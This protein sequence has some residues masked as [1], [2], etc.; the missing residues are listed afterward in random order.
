MSKLRFLFTLT[1]IPVLA[2]AFTGNVLAKKT[3]E[4]IHDAEYYVLEAQHGKKWAAEDKELDKKLAKMRKKHGTPP[5][6]IHIMWDDTAVGE[7]GV[8]Q[9]QKARGWETPNINKFS[10]EGIYFARMYTEPSCTPSRAAVMTGRHAVRNGMY[11][12]GFPYEYGGLAADEVTMGEVLSKAGYATAF[13]G[14]SHMGDVES[15]YL[16]KQGFDEALWTPYNQV[17]SMYPPEFERMGAI[18]PGSLNDNI[19]PNDPYDI[20]KGWKPTGYVFALEGV[21]GGPVSEWGTAP[22]IE[23]YIAVDG[24]CQKRLSKF[25]KKNVEAK[26]PF[27]AAYWPQMTPF[28]GFPEKITVSAGMLQEAIARFDVYVGEL[29]EELKTLGIEE[30]TLVI[31][32]ADNGPMIHHGPTGMVETL[33][34]GGKGDFLEGGVRVTAHARWPGV[35]EKGQIVGDIIHETD[36]FTTFANLADAKKYI[37]TDRIIDGIDQTALFLK[38]DTHSRRDYVFIYTGDQLAATVKGRYKRDWRNAVPGLSGA[39]FYDLYNDPREVYP[40]M[41]QL[42]PVKTMFSIMKTRHLMM[43]KA[44]P[45]KGQNRDFPFKNVVNARPETVKASKPRLDP[46]KLPFDP[47]EAIMQVPE[48]DNLDQGWGAG[49]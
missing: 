33:Y 14:K 41:L 24:E 34:R 2:L 19:I 16:N 44:Y 35:I 27:Y 47:R 13:Y 21:K 22:N 7:V 49:E 32:M 3:A 29:M 37:P 25:M 5:N 30:N 1:V 43:I 23:D 20:D 46:K 39:E 4:I 17:P 36:L 31:L 15:S 10:A 26:K 18:R 48:W 11:N 38:G 6:I 9:I 8:P 40:F 12:V 28:T 45:N 42:F